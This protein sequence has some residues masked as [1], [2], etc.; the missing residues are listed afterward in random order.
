MNKQIYSIYLYTVYIINYIVNYISKSQ[1]H[2]RPQ[3]RC[4]L[5]R[6][7]HIRTRIWSSPP[8]KMTKM[9]ESSKL[10]KPKH[11]IMKNAKSASW[12]PLTS[13]HGS[14]H[15]NAMATCYQVRTPWKGRRTTLQRN[16]QIML[17]LYEIVVYY[18]VVISSLPA[19]PLFPSL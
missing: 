1:N 2:I 14:E 8:Q 15:R 6:V 18:F 9:S 16:A 10:S 7:I 17:N 5:I 19:L 4:Q 12:G 13:R 3:H 11:S